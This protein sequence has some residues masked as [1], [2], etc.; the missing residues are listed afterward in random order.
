MVVCAKG[1]MGS[2]GISSEHLERAGRGT[3]LA[4]WGEPPW[5]DRSL[6]RQPHCP[7]SEGRSA[8][9]A[10]QSAGI[11]VSACVNA[12]PTA[13]ASYIWGGTKWRGRNNAQENTKVIKIE[14]W[15]TVCSL[16]LPCFYHPL[17]E[18]RVTAALSAPPVAEGLVSQ[19]PRDRPLPNRTRP[20]CWNL[21]NTR[22]I[23]LLADVI[24]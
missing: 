1:G 12:A 19:R 6:A 21:Y 8:P 5:Q 3:L 11:L 15:A 23:V 4:N 9:G 22:Y 24:L 14:N 13:E 16:R 18:Q 2:Q 10:R 7:S 20:A 17:G